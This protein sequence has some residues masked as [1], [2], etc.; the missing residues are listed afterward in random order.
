MGAWHGAHE[1]TLKPAFCC[2]SSAA[3]GGQPSQFGWP[4]RQRPALKPPWPE[5]DQRLTCL[6]S[7]AT[8]NLRMQHTTSQANPHTGILAEATIGG[9]GT[10]TPDLASS[11]PHQPRRCLG[12]RKLPLQ[13]TPGAP[14][15]FWSGFRFLRPTS[16][17][18][19][20]STRHVSGTP[21]LAWRRLSA[22][23]PA[24]HLICPG[25]AP[26]LR[27][28]L[29]PPLLRIPRFC[30]AVRQLRRLVDLFGTLSRQTPSRRFPFSNRV[31]RSKD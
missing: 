31:R 20:P 14:A 16:R 13:I 2:K 19:V 7:Q 28:K 6:I 1:P 18:G 17:R 5:Q 12:R 9:R 22:A 24:R 27:M 29:C 4:V 21:G 15:R 30:V 10:T 8:C 25:L 26:F 23:H 3:S 11:E